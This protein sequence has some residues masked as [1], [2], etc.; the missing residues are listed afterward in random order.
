MCEVHVI[1]LWALYSY[2]YAFNVNWVN[3]PALSPAPR[4]QTGQSQRSRGQLRP[5]SDSSRPVLHWVQF[6]QIF[7]ACRLAV[8]VSNQTLLNFV[9]GAVMST[10]SIAFKATE[11]NIMFPLCPVNNVIALLSLRS[12]PAEKRTKNKTLNSQHHPLPPFL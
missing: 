2:K 8:W 1:S 12:N 11:Q 7:S 10:V 6:I 5:G 4:S 3:W 9:P